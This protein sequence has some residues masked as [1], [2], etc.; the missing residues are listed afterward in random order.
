MNKDSILFDSVITK[1]IFIR[2]VLENFLKNEKPEKF[3]GHRYIGNDIWNECN[4]ISVD[5]IRKYTRDYVI[6]NSK[7]KYYHIHRNKE[8]TISILER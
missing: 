1:K 4:N 8:K 7:G 5:K 2:E 6:Y 3:R